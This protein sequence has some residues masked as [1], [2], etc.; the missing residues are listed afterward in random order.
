VC[1][2][3]KINTDGTPGACTFFQLLEPTATSVAIT[4][5]QRAGRYLW[6]VS[7]NTA[8]GDLPQSAVFSY[9]IP[10]AWTQVK[11]A[12]VGAAQRDPDVFGE[13]RWKTNAPHEKV[14]TAWTARTKKR[15]LCKETRSTAGY[16]E[17]AYFDCFFRK[18]RLLPR[19][20]RVWISVRAS[21]GGQ[22]RT[23]TR[24]FVARIN[25]PGQRTK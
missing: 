24:S 10:I 8:S 13:L 4:K 15:T 7:Y 1:A 18:A 22:A 14:V 25:Y 21:H 9:E 16:Q 5:E 3:Y 12:K 6:Y 17:K 11:M 19:G 23:I 20:T 2:T